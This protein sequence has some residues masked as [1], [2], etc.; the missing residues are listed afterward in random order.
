MRLKINHTTRYSYDEPVTYGLQQIRLTPSD[1][2]QQRVL[3][4]NVDIE[5]GHME[6][7]FF[8]QHQNL[9]LLAQVEAGQSEV[10]VVA[11]GE[12]ETTDT[13]GVLGKFYGIAPLWH[14]TQTTPRTEAG[15]SVRKLAKIIGSSD[16]ALNDLHSL[17]REI[18]AIAPYNRSSTF[19]DTTAEQALVAGG[20]VCQDHAQIFI[21]A[22][23][24]CGI[25]ARYVS[26]YLM[27]N[28]QVD[29][30]ASHAWAEAHVDGIGWVG[31]DVSNRI[32]PDERYVRLATGL[33]SS[34]ASPI[35]GMRQGAS[36]EAMMVSLQVQQ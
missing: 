10:V 3:D 24:H 35:R 19:V 36:A 9:T 29:Q 25:P 5:G 32:S 33:D 27:M 4:W 30:E 22:A 28:G 12:V 2:S 21:S 1:N 17:S 15:K 34:D 26:G 20:G 11:K 31:F 18:L 13:A 6:L 7:S 14:F 23:R 16:N 8:D